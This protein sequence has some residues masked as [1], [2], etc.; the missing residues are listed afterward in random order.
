MSRRRAWGV[1]MRGLSFLA[2]VAVTTVACSPDA[3]APRSSQPFIRD[4]DGR[5]LI[6]RG[7]NVSSSAKSA[8]DRLPDIDAGDPPLL[9]RQF[10]FNF[11]RY[12]IFWDAVEPQ[13]GAIDQAYLDAVERSF[14]P[15][16]P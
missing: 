5:V 16:A 15:P 8:P 2:I 7:T 3:G 4:R 13:P 6:L 12:L 9:A 10:G 11:A 1:A 14:L